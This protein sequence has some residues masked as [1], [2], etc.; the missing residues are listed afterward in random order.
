MALHVSGAIMGLSCPFVGAGGQGSFSLLA[1]LFLGKVVS[2][3][4]QGSLW[5][6][7]HRP[8]DNGLQVRDVVGLAQAA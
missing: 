6:E 8:D 3:Y 1:E 7:G 4:A 5:R 2:R